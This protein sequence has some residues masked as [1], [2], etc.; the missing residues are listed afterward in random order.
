M[1]MTA[2]LQTI[3]NIFS[4]NRIPVSDLNF[5]IRTV[6]DKPVLT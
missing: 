6:N 2:T 1:K 4:Y 3:F 5:L